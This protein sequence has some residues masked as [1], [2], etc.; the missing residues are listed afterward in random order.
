MRS[1]SNPNPVRFTPDSD[2][3]LA[4]DSVELVY[5]S[6]CLEH[7]DDPT[8]ARALSEARR[9]LRPDGAL[10]I[11]L[12]DFDLVLDDWR[13]QDPLLISAPVWN[14]ESLLPMWDARGVADTLDNRVAVIFCGFWNDA[15][16]DENS[17][18]PG[19]GKQSDEAYLGPSVMAAEA[20][21]ELAGRAQPHEI[22]AT[23]RQHV[24]DMEPTYTFNHQNSWGRAE[25]EAVLAEAGFD[26]LSFEQDKIVAR[27][28]WVPLI[29]DMDHMNFYCLAVPAMDRHG[30]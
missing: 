25:F 19:D 6:H 2:F 20:L 8:V 10:L 27:Y 26:V 15:Y 5:S 13:R 30:A 4:D 18:F 17:L 16:G 9:I 12:L 22:A 28:R 23:L 24:L 1:D 7:L 11:K 29:H 3:P 21:R 14:I